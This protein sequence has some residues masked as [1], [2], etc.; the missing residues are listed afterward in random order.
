MA[1][2]AAVFLQGP[3]M[4]EPRTNS[5][6]KIAANPN[7]GSG[8]RRGSGKPRGESAG[9]SATGMNVLVAVLAVGLAAAGWF[10]VT[11]HLELTKAETSLTEA[12]HRLAV[13]EERS[14]AT[15]QAMSQSGTEVQGKLGQ[16]ETEI[17]KLWD[18]AKRD[19]QSITENENKLKAQDGTINGM[20][21]SLKELTG[22]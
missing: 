22:V 20:Q 13:L 6:P 18:T 3:P 1:K 11:Q 17:R 15:D 5:A 12:D 16:W 19:K 9:R 7:E 2:L 8:Y 21:T 4:S 14:Q 10:I